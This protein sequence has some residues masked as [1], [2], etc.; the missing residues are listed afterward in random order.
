[1]VNTL[2]LLDAM[3]AHKVD[4]FIFSSTAATFGEPQYS[5]MDE[6]QLQQPIKP[7]GRTK[8]MVEQVLADYDQ[9]YGLHSV[10]LR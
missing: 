5:P 1:M 2:K 10:S 8:L 7:Y 4:C 3:R 9:A 6:R